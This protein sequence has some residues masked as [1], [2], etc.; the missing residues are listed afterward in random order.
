MLPS[1]LWLLCVAAVGATAQDDSSTGSGSRTSSSSS[2]TT[3]YEP[4][5]GQTS[6][7]FTNSFSTIT[8]D[9][10]TSAFTGSEYTYLSPNGQSTVQTLTTTR[11]ANGT[12]ETLTSTSTSTQYSQITRTTKSVSLTVIGG[13]A[14]NSTAS[15]T[16]NQTASSTSSSARPTNTVPC[17]GFPEFCNRKYSNIT[18]V[19]AH[20][21]AFV[22]KNNAASNQWYPIR[23]QL[24]DG[25]R[26]RTWKS[27][28]RLRYIANMY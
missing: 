14:S 3:S 24:N 23:D 28:K 11:T 5:D 16:R 22:V 13:D 19:V 7:S 12:V 4:G 10:P 26:M 1:A 15:S 6:L 8:G 2:S 17:N 18:Q 27:I 25:V 21:S 9:I 20:N